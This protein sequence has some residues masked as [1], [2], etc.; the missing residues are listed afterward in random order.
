MQSLL[1][2]SALAATV[3]RT[4]MG[5]FAPTDTSHGHSD[6]WLA[7]LEAKFAQRNDHLYVHLIPHSHDDVGW[8]KT[9]DE[10][11]TGSAQDI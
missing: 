7:N 9:P 5:A 10:Y 8:L 6:E 2:K 4:S 11:F 3:A 1:V